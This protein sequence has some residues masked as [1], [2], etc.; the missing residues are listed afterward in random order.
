[1]FG[2]G[3]IDS[4]KI[5]VDQLR[6]GQIRL[7]DETVPPDFLGVEEKELVFDRD[8]KMNGEAYLA[9]DDLVIHLQVSTQARLPCAICNEQVYVKMEIEDL[10]LTKPTAEIKS[11]VYDF[12]EALREEILLEVP[13]FA[14]CHNGHCPHREEMKKYLK[15]KQDH[16]EEEGYHPFAEL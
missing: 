14:E 6:E 5:F 13:H 9:S 7:I 15:D 1:M 4:F 16:S 10:Y 2:R 8:V 12:S 3:M 11:A